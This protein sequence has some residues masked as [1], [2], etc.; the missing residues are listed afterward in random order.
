MTG[1]AGRRI[2]NE[3]RRS[4]EMKS[5]KNIWKKRWRKS[6]AVAAVTVVLL[7]GGAVLLAE[8]LAAKGYLD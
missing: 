4:I 5:I 1:D 7:A 6:A 3:N 2:R 8:L